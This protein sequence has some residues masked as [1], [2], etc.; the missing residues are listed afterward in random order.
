MTL[1]NIRF[2]DEPASYTERPQVYLGS[3]DDKDYYAILYAHPVIKEINLYG[4]KIHALM[5]HADDDEI[6]SAV[7]EEAKAAA[8]LRGIN[9]T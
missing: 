8:K 3:A 1:S 6:L 4:L 9:A 2:Y 7:K 5:E